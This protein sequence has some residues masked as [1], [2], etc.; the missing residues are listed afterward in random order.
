MAVIDHLVYAVP[1]LADAITQ[2]ESATGVRP[3]IGGSHRGQGTHNALVSFGENYL[4]LVAPDP[5]QPTPAGPR[6]FGI[7]ALDGPRLV[8]FAVRPDSSETI[9]GLVDSARAAEFDL[10]EIVPMSRMQPSGEELHWRLTLPR[11]ELGGGMPFIIDW[12]A[13][14]QP[15]ATAPKGIELTDFR[16]LHG[17]TG[18]VDRAH[19]ALGIAIGVERA[20]HQMLRATI[21]GR[22]GSIEL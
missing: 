8:T 1:V 18:A 10:G 11:L 3:A 14:A 16:I 22:L 5:G 20:N 19:H 2:F 17:D 4:E 7:D 21:S 9:E 6:P 12:G 13:T 15:A